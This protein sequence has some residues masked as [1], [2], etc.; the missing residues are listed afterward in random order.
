MPFQNNNNPS[1]HRYMKSPAWLRQLEKIIKDKITWQPNIISAMKLFIICPLLLLT[2]KQINILPNSSI[3]LLCLYLLFALLDYLDGTVARHRGIETRFGRMLDRTAD[4]PL[5]LAAAWGCR[6]ILSLSLLFSKASIDFL[7]IV[8]YGTGRKNTEN[9]IRTLLNHTT[10]LFLIFLS[11]GWGEPF[12]N[13]EIVTYFIGIN[14]L[15][16]SVIIFYSIGLLKKKYIAD[17]LSGANLCCG[18]FSMIFAAKGR[19]D[20]SLLFLMVGAAFDG[21]DGAAARKF[22]GT[23][24]GVYSDDIADGVN[25]GIAPGVAIHFVI[26]GLEGLV[27]GIF[28][29]SFTIS[30]L[31]FFTLNKNNS[32]PDYFCGAPS[33]VGALLTLS[34]LSLFKS[35][36]VI[37]GLMVGISCIQMVSFDTHYRHLG[38]ALAENRRFVFGIPVVILLLLSGKHFWDIQGAIAVIFVISIIYGFIPTISHFMKFTRNVK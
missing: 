11:Q 16:S 22:G 26:G 2:F 36:P 21:F 30:R 17:A 25:Y 27:T 5:I 1:S 10:I 31:I 33:T 29:S 8:L 34:A 9:R 19:V 32:D 3:L 13:V 35:T 24:W 15:Y 18:I 14:I 20:I 37:F 6:H 38:R 7:I 23:K 12:L 28:Y 4:F